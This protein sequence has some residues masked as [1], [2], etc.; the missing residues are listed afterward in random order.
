MTAECWRENSYLQSLTGNGG[1]LRLSTPATSGYYR[2]V[3]TYSEG[4]LSD[5][6]ELEGIRYNSD[7]L[8]LNDDRNW[9][10][11]RTFNC[12]NHGDTEEE[13]I[14]YD[15]SYYDG[16][17][18]ALQNV[19][20]CA[21]GDGQGDI[22][23]PF[24]YDGLYREELQYLPYTLDANN[25]QSDDAALANQ[26][27][28]YKTRYGLATDPHACVRTEYEPS[29]LNRVLRTHKPGAEYQSDTR[30][31]QTFYMGNAVSTVLRL[32]VDPD[33]RSL[34]ADGYYAAN[35]LSGTRSTNEDGAVV[36]TYADKEGRTV[37]E[38]RQLRNGSAT[39]NIITYYAYDDCGRLAWVMTPK[40]SDLL[41][42]GS[43]FSPDSDFAKQN[44][45]VYFYDEWGRVY[46]NVSRD[47]SRC[48]S[49]TTGAIG[50]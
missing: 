5:S 27:E 15:V 39:E 33:D 43:S 46:E 3:A 19:Q 44:C 32:R 21:N 30:S 10:L 1:S 49:S 4:G 6:A 16:L 7:M 47:A 48:M 14:S 17:G 24:V 13:Q 25:G 41:S 28:F 20:I 9:I 22:I 2:I 40:G 38:N 29:A 12:D 37:Y 18:Y 45:Y 26:E 23:Q 50:R 42:A 36:I 31:M 8:S 35:E 11:T 34:T